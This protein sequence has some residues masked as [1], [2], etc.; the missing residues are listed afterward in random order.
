MFSVQ[1]FGA[2]PSYSNQNVAYTDPPL[3]EAL[4]LHTNG[5][6]FSSGDTIWFKAYNCDSRNLKPSGLSQFLNVCLLNSDGEQLLNQKHKLQNGQ[7]HGDL[8]LPDSLKTGSYL[9]AAY[10]NYFDGKNPEN[11]FYKRIKLTSENEVQ[12]KIVLKDSLYALGQKLEGSIEALG[13]NGVRLGKVKIQMQLVQGEVVVEKYNFNI[14]EDGVS[15]F[16]IYIPDLISSKEPL[17]L[18]STL[19]HAQLTGNSTLYIPLKQLAPDLQFFPEGGD[20]IANTLTNIAFKAIDAIGNPFD[21]SGEIV[22]KDGSVVTTI[23]SQILGMG[24]LSLSYVAEDSLQLKILQPSGYDQSYPLPQPIDSGYIFRV[25]EML[26]DEIKLSIHSNL[27]SPETKHTISVQIRN[28]N[29]FTKTLPLSELNSYSIPTINF[30][31]GVACITLLDENGIPKAERLVFVNQDRKQHIKIEN[32]KKTYKNKDQVKIDVQLTNHLGKPVFGNFSMSVVKLD[33]DYVADWEE[34]IM[35]TLLL[36]PELRGEI[37]C[38]G[39]YFSDDSLAKQALDL[40]ML[41][42]GWR[43]FKSDKSLSLNEVQFAGVPETKGI[44]G[45]VV[46]PNGKPA[47]NASLVL[48]NAENF[49]ALNVH[50][51][52]TGKF[53]IDGK[54]FSDLADAKSLVLSATG[55]GGNTNLKI[56]IEPDNLSLNNTEISFSGL[57]SDARKNYYFTQRNKYEKEKLDALPD[58]SK[59][60][61]SLQGVTITARKKVIFQEEVYTKKF[62]SK[63]VTGDELSYSLSGG[64]NL[65]FLDMMR[66]VAGHFNVD[67]DMGKILFR[68]FNHVYLSK[69]QGAAIVV[70]EKLVG[71]DYREIMHMDPASFES[72]EVFK[73][74]NAALKYAPNG[75]GGLIKITLKKGF[76]EQEITELNNKKSSNIETIPGFKVAREFYSPIYSNDDQKKSILD[77]RNTLFWEPNLIIGKLGKKKIHFYNSDIK[78]NFLIQIEG[79]DELGQAGFA[80]KTYIVK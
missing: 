46:K 11:V 48:F 68:G 6:V 41:T 66:K 5:S 79:I 1:T 10:S 16:S 19:N 60:S 52:K 24:E 76:S 15:D 9:L 20:V 7:A 37:V 8:F 54:G 33:S 27:K 38:P 18:Q 30:P 22:H 12:L 39:F 56:L 75:F 2:P 49:G 17:L 51:D 65:A 62:A 64:T 80:T 58:F 43:R 69:Q 73:S 55:S 3:H 50:T 67:P 70:D 72:I 14:G 47:K 13:V 53:S 21:F 61:I 31:I 29:H 25:D 35:S 57:S 28:K 26:K 42:N 44:N 63:K 77:L 23:S 74:S 78:G 36:K 4:Y 45:R 34:N 71:F 40:L 59:E 32:L